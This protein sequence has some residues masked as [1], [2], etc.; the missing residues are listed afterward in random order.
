M[1]SIALR[2]FG[3]ISIALIFGVTTAS[4]ATVDQVKG[5]VQVNVGNGFSP[6]QG[7]VQVPPGAAVM[8]AP[9]SSARIIYANNCFVDVAPGQVI[10]VV[11][12]DQ[13]VPAAGAG[14]LNGLQLGLGA[15]L[16]AGGIG[17]VVIIVN[18]S[19]DKPASP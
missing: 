14:G 15:A 1:A 2:A 11:P 13:C 3:A 7:A 10:T 8:A 9:G 4:A 16:I 6:I 17:A 5:D 18:K 12:D 19:D